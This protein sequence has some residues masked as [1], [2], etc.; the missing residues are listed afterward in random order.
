MQEVYLVVREKRRLTLRYSFRYFSILLMNYA[1]LR[2]MR[3][4]I[5]GYINTGGVL[6]LLTETTA[7]A[8]C[9]HW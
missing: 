2:A 9:L 8:A 7:I 1:Q 3:F 6:L 4:V 5:Y